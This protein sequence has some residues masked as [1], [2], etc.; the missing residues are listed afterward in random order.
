MTKEMEVVVCNPAKINNNNK[1]K[2]GLKS[3]RHKG[4]QVSDHI[5]LDDRFDILKDRP[6]EISPQI[7]GIH[8]PSSAKFSVDNSRRAVDE[9]N[10]DK[11]AAFKNTKL[12]AVKSYQHQESEDIE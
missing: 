4:R 7:K 11:Q 8:S 1:N 2:N 5:T 9:G 12:D 10:T 6:I 3:Q